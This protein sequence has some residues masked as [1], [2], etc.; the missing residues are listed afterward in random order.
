MVI[1]GIAANAYAGDRF[2]E[3]DSFPKGLADPPHTA[4]FPFK[5]AREHAFDLGNQPWR[6]DKL[7]LPVLAEHDDVTGDPPK[8]MAEM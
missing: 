7:D 4:L 5:L 6:N 1:F 2:H 3:S 8:T